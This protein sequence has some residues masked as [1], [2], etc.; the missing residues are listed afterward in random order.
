MNRKE[1]SFP[2]F[3]VWNMVGISCS[4]IK[5][6]PFYEI[7]KYCD[8]HTSYIPIKYLHVSRR[9]S[10][11]NIHNATMYFL[12]EIYNKFED[13]IIHSMRIKYM[14]LPRRHDKNHPN[15]S[16]P[17][18]SHPDKS[19]PDKSPPNMRQKPPQNI[20]SKS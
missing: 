7:S 14:Y 9:K 6:K 18:I 8:N 5:L 11:S 16:H 19:H 12:K 17:D 13:Y 1:I 4:H 3:Y 20:K 15:K 2:I 10:N